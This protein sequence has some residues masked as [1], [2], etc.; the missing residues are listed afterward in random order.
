MAGL[1]QQL[2][3]PLFR[4]RSLGERGE[5]LAA[6]YLR[7][8]GYR[9]LTRNFQT[10]GGE[11]DIVAREGDVLI[12]VEVKTRRSDEQRQPW[13]QVNRAKQHRMTR[14]ARAYLRHYQQRTPPARFDVV[15]I[16]WPETHKP[17]IE[18]F[19]NAFPATF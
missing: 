7:K 4:R 6:D 11:I 1:I 8:K 16:V 5:L 15:S 17:R 14:A 3:A 13:Q 2:F 10:V 19:T 12:F 18:H 9:V